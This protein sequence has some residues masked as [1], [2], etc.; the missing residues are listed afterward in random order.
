MS[1]RTLYW[2]QENPGQ[3][4]RAG[5][6]GTKRTAIVTG[7][8]HPTGIFV[9][10]DSSRLFWADYHAHKI[11][12]SNLGGGD[13][14]DIIQLPAKSHP[15]GVVLNGNRIYWG[16]WDFSLLQSCDISGH[17]VQTLYNGTGILQMVLMD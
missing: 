1:N 15:W 16:T 3:I 11:Q 12:S 13:V 8:K 7:L 6:D 14:R 10:L 9:D 4:V 5:M 2:T 17:D